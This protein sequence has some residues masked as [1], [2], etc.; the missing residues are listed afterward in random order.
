M[1]VGI[2]TRLSYAAEEDQ[3]SIKRQQ[4]DCEQLAATRG[5]QVVDHYTDKNRSGWKRGVKREQFERLLRDL[6]LGKLD[7]VIG[8]KLDRFGRNPRDHVLL[9]ET[10]EKYDKH[11]AL[12]KEPIDLSSAMGKGMADIQAIF[13]R[14]E[15]ENISIRVKSAW[16]EKA[17]E[18][19]PHKNGARPFGLSEDW[20]RSPEYEHEVALI[21][22]A[23]NRIL[24]GET[25][26]SVATDWN[27]RG[28]FTTRDNRWTRAT[29]VQ[30]LTQPRLIGKRVHNG[31]SI[32]SD[33]I[34]IMVDSVADWR[35]VEKK[36]K[37]KKSKI[38]GRAPKY[39]L[40]GIASCGLCGHNLLARVHTKKYATH[41]LTLTWQ[42]A[43][44]IG[45]PW[46]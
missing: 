1:K 24:A 9:M 11:I 38:G 10:L 25:A 21:N 45:G 4:E 15:S 2:Y 6:E 31:R 32:A 41:S 5:W 40:S 8:W 20:T 22:E 13:A 19:K 18:G 14:M 46:G 42:C 30:M 33:Y 43:G 35:Q 28:I 36:L 3:T 34:P 16:L 7:G 44:W 27:K 17:N 26:N 39:L 23:I 29:L 12:V 37:P